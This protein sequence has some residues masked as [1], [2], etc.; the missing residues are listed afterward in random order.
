MERTTSSSTLRTT[1]M[2]CL[3]IVPESMELR[4]MN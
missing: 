2:F 1:V 3:T 4:T